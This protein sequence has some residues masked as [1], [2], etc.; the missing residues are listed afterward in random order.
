MKYSSLTWHL[1]AKALRTVAFQEMQCPLNDGRSGCPS[2]R[3]KKKAP[4]TTRYQ[5]QIIWVSF[6]IIVRLSFCTSDS[7]FIQE[8]E[9]T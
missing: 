1:M 4:L 8:I 2:L 5:R 9:T 6:L 3:I 7:S